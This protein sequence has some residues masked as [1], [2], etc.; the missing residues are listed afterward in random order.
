MT[1]TEAKNKVISLAKSEVGYVEGSDNWNKYAAEL[2]PLGITWGNKQNLAWCGEFVLWVFYRCFGIEK[3]L[4]SM[5]SPNPTGIPLCKM[6]AT[7]FQEAKRWYPSPKIGDVIFFYYGGDINHTGIVVSVS[8]GVVTTV[9]GNSGDGVRQNS[10]ATGSPV[11]AGYGRPNWEV[12]AGGTSVSTEPGKEPLKPAPENPYCKI[13]LKL[14]ELQNGDVGNAV[15]FLQTVLPFHGS[16]YKCGVWGAD[17]EFGS[18]TQN[19]VE[20]F[21]KD[22]GLVVDSIVGAATWFALLQI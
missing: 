18:A 8:G 1:A 5:Y 21:Q 6:G 3:G 16:R 2:D 14:P 19:A 17:G 20:K 11:I 15:K 22:K 13:E 4:A 7:Y 12:A 10:Y 9:E